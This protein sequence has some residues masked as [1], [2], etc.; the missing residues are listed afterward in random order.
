V[1]SVQLMDNYE[2]RK[3]VLLFVIKDNDGLLECRIWIC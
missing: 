2:L 1:K 3:T